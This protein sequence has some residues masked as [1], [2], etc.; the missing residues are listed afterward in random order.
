[1]GR[2]KADIDTQVESIYLSELHATTKRE[3]II[4]KR[5]IQTGMCE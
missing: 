3:I 2:V 4:V 1:M 5:E